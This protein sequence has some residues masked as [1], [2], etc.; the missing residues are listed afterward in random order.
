MGVLD[1]Q[2]HSQAE[3]PAD[4]WTM[5][6]YDKAGTLLKS[7]RIAGPRTRIGDTIWI[8]LSTPYRDLFDKAD[9]VVIGADVQLSGS[10]P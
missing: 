8:K 1:V 2:I 3:I 10:K 4:S 7:G 9:R 5:S 6:A